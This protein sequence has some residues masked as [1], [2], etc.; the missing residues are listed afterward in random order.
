[1]TAVIVL[2]LTSAA[3]ARAALDATARA[4]TH[5]RVGGDE[6]ARRSF[7][8]RLTAPVLE[9]RAQQTIERELPNVLDSVSRSLR[10]GSSLRQAIDEASAVAPHPLGRDLSRVRRALRDGDPLP[11]ALARWASDRPL[12]GVRLAVA[13]LSLGA[14]TGGASAQAI[15][16]VSATLRTNLAIAGEV[17]ALSSQARLSALVIALAPIAFS[18]LAFTTD[19]TTAS[20]LFGTPLGLLCLV[21]GLGLDAVGW[22]WMRRLVAAV[23]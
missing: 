10:S 17:R 22:L 12:S 20:F 15:D 2:L 18:S 11:D 7:V 23:A 21:A 8:R 14:E 4:K 1:M 3:A 5:A 19:A 13:A 6:R 9:R 16:G